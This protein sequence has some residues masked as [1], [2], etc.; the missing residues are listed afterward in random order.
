MARLISLRNITFVM[1]MLLFGL[2]PLR[3]EPQAGGVGGY[4][5]EFRAAEIGVYGHSY[6]AFGRLNANGR[7]VSAQYADFH[8]VSGNL[9]MAV[10]HF[11]PVP[12]AMT[13]DKT[14]FALPL[15]TVFRRR[16][17]A[18][19][20]RRLIAAIAAERARARPW[21]AIVYNCNDFVADIAR[22]V[23]LHAPST[24]LF[25]NAFVSLLKDMNDAPRQAVDANHRT[26][27][28]RHPRETARTPNV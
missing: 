4:F 14:T 10:G 27:R 28:T 26:G 16:I 11:L 12:S 9:G 19:D 6:V 5:V 22:A 2:S 15:T 21:N 3:A 20:Y 13:P 8:P 23:G 17:G 24:M 18:A 1:A 7:P 25:A